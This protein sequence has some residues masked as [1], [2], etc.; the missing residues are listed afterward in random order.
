MLRASLLRQEGGEVSLSSRDADRDMQPLSP[1]D[2]PFQRLVGAESVE[3]LRW[4]ALG[5]ER[6]MGIGLVDLLDG[7]PPALA[8]W[9]PAST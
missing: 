3:T 5:L 9:Y 7:A 1:A 2:A 8:S 6:A 4:Y